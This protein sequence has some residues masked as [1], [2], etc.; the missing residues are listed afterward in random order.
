M[1]DLQCVFIY[2]LDKAVNVTDAA[3]KKTLYMIFYDLEY[4]LCEHQFT[5]SSKHYLE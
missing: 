2:N 1:K 5:I 4:Y 3:R